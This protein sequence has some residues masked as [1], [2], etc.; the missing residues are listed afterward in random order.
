MLERDGVVDAIPSYQ[1]VDF[2]RRAEEREDA[3][4]DAVVEIRKKVLD[5]GVPL[6]SVARE[7]RDVVFPIDDETKDKREKAAL[8]LAATRLRDML[9]SS[10]AVSQ[11][12]AGDVT[13][14]L[15]ELIVALADSK[16]RA[17]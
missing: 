10:R 9:A 7:S 4:Q 16:K 13:E 8:K 1:A 12:L 11:R 3:P 5:E 15:D 14:K 17:A 2:L 6:P